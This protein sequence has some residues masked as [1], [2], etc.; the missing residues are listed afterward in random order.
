M[1][2]VPSSVFLTWILDAFVLYSCVLLLHSLRGRLSLAPVF[3]MVGFVASVMMWIGGN[4]A[5]V[6]FAGLTVYWGSTLYAGLVLA[7]MLLYALDGAAAARSVILA[8][9]GVTAATYILTTG[10][11]VQAS[12]GLILLDIPIPQPPLRSYLASCFSSVINLIA[13]AVLWELLGRLRVLGSLLPRVFI[14]LLL[15]LYIDSLLYVTISFYDSPHY[16]SILRGNVIDRLLLTLFMSPFLMLYIRWQQRASGASLTSGDLFGILKRH[17]NAE[18]Q[19]EQAKAEAE[20]ER[21]RREQSERYHGTLLNL[22]DLVGVDLKEFFKTATESLAGAMGVARVSIWFMDSDEKGMTCQSLYRMDSASHES[23]MELLEKDFPNYFKSIRNHQSLL[24]HE[25]ATN[26]ATSEFVDVYLAP[27]GITSMLDVPIRLA[28]STIGVL[29]C[30]HVGP[31]RHWAQGDNEFAVAAASY[32]ALALQQ[33]ER[34]RA[35]AALREQ[36]EQYRTLVQ[37]IP[38]VTFRCKA[39]DA[40]TMLYVSDAVEELTGYPASDFLHNAVRPFTSLIHPE[41]KE[42]VAQIVGNACATG[43]T[44]TLSYRILHADGRIRWVGV[45]G[46]PALGDDGAVLYIDGVG[47]DVTER[48]EAELALQM[49]EQRY[50]LAMEAAADGL[51]DWDVATGEVFY[52]PRW[53]QMLGYEPHE[54]PQNIKTWKLLV[55]PEDID[56]ALSEEE[57]QMELKGGAFVVEFRMLSKSGEYRWILSRGKVT[58]RDKN[59][60]AKRVLGTHTDITDLKRAIERSQRYEF[61]INAV[62]DAMSFVSRDYH[63]LAVND[64]WCKTFNLDRSKVLGVPIAVIWG[65]EI[66]S[67]DIRPHLDS[68]LRGESDTY[69]EWITTPDGVHKCFEVSVFPYREEGDVI[70]HAVIVSHEITARM[71]VEQERNA[72]D[73]RLRR[74]FDTATEG[75][76][77][78]DKETRTLQVNDALCRIL[79]R[80]E[81]EILGR[82]ISEFATEAG[83]AIQKEQIS[84][85]ANGESGAYEMEYQLPSGKTVHCLVSA[86]PM[87]EDGLRTGS[88]AMITDLTELKR[89]EAAVRESEAYFRAVFDNAGVGIVSKNAEGRFLRANEAFLRMLGYSADELEHLTME[90]VT[91]A[92]DLPHTRKLMG[93]LARGEREFFHIEKRYICKDGS[94]RWCDVRT[95]SIRGADGAFSTTITA[96]TDITQLK[97]L[98]EAIAAAKDEAENATRAKSDFLATMSHEIR[99][100]MNAIIG[101]AH[102]ALKTELSPKQ[103]DYVR[104]IQSAATTL[105]G[106]IND[107]L[108]F[109]KIEAGKLDLEHV[110]FT[111]D[112]VLENLA[113]LLTVR[114]RERDQLEVLFNNPTTVPRYLV[115]DPLRLGQILVNLGSNAVKFTRQGEIVVSVTVV[116]MGETE[117]VLRFA[118]KDTGIGMT[119]EQMERLFQPFSQADSSTTRQYGGT[120][121]GLTICKSL[122]E[123]MGGRIWMESQSGAGSTFYFEAPFGL[124]HDMA[125]VRAAA[126][127]DKVRGLRVMVVDDSATSREILTSILV[128][129]GY[130]VVEVSSGADALDVLAHLPADE[131]VD[132]V[133]MDWKMPGMDGIRCSRKIRQL[134]LHTPPRIILVTAYGRED[135]MREAVE[136]TLD[137]IVLKPVSQSILFDAVLGAFGEAV[138]EQPAN[139]DDG[140][141]SWPTLNGLFVLLAEDNEINQQ[142]AEELLASVGVK[143]HIAPN[144]LLAVQAMSENKFDMVLMDCQMPVMDGFEATRS[145]RALPNVGPIPILAMTANAMAGDRDR[146]IEAGMNDHIPKPIDPDQLFQTMAKH[147]PVRNMESAELVQPVAIPAPQQQAAELPNEIAGINMASGLRRVNGNRA[148]YL[149]LLRQFYTQNVATCQSIRDALSTRDMGTAARL[150]HTVKGVGAN[151]GAEA[152]AQ[153]AKDVEQLLKQEVVDVDAIERALLPLAECLDLVRAALA[154]LMPEGEVTLGDEIDGVDVPEAAYLLRDLLVLIDHDLGAVGD[155]IAEL[156]PQLGSAES[157]RLLKEVERKLNDFDTDGAKFAIEQL[158]NVRPLSNTEATA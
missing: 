66:F 35:Q 10:L 138:E 34:V 144:G 109:S 152:V 125:A 19:L 96:V 154:P 107:I 122:V 135:V 63:Y 89:A 84:R 129:F 46:Q 79:Q 131:R 97:V 30:E 143:V 7:A 56:R 105:L 98:Y 40:F 80:P 155:R 90:H 20:V 150:A 140:Q 70:S 38:G 59:G 110:D 133:L 24:A 53:F 92:E 54:F 114:A 55:H 58:L 65:E 9:I 41:D 146:C 47:S 115:G 126:L 73:G 48:R 68:V 132:L 108:D 13:M 99:T 8:I 82:R 45:K 11:N 29:C 14:T 137:G 49:S 2:I 156:R 23:G 148:L 15:T 43:S 113:D 145:I 69:E 78:I 95:T 139:T 32:I 3:I 5:R 67:R 149:R 112:S 153:A 94:L 17:S 39:D 26:P 62:Q 141:G 103:R 74:I 16:V 27:L 86:A 25:A 21:A 42:M 117:C 123:M 87:Y 111:L 136:A 1:P 121:L 28:G 134:D 151:I 60:A 52:N 44:I 118:I 77:V 104:K 116:E 102:L 124:Q 36:E 12:Q 81:Q 88:F 101:M 51:Y 37:N 127:T 85:R 120:G 31:Q 91:Y 100:P 83:L 6:E 119:T 76:W 157:R 64:A 93:Q 71:L 4:G 33:T 61:I 158:L 50:D 147:A 22:R 128:S 57:E 142:V 72:A 130:T 106:I 18:R 75:I